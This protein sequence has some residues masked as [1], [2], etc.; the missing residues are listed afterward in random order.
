[1][2]DQKI[3][4][5]L[6]IRKLGHPNPTQ[7]C[8][9]S[10]PSAAG[11]PISR[12]SRK[13]QTKTIAS[14]TGP[15]SIVYMLDGYEVVQQGRRRERAKVRRDEEQAGGLAVLFE[16]GASLRPVSEQVPPNPTKIYSDWKQTEDW[17]KT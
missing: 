11:T 12:R 16:S 2:K 7:T 8:S 10:F 9:S 4:T 1:M 14:D 6:E 17:I 15:S 3:Q 13:H 5:N